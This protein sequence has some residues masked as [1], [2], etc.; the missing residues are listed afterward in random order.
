[1]WFLTSAIIFLQVVANLA[2]LVTAYA[3]P[4]ILPRLFHF[5]FVCSS[6]SYQNLAVY[7]PRGRLSRSI[8]EA[9]CCKT[10]GKGRTSR[11]G[12]TTGLWSGPFSPH[13]CFHSCKLSSSGRGIA[14][15][16]SPLPVG[17]GK[18]LRRWMGTCGRLLWNCCPGRRSCHCNV[19]SAG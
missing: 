6:E 15:S 14:W 19:R 13:R 16:Q 10:I 11:R 4:G 5:S 12:W 2:F 17:R 7:Q 9:A 3:N 8:L 18:L 1:M